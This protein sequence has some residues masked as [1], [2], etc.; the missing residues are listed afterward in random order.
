MIRSMPSQ[1]ETLIF[2]RRYLTV[3]QHSTDFKT[4]MAFFPLSV[5]RYIQED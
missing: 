1:K 4:K 3:S 5:P 2:I